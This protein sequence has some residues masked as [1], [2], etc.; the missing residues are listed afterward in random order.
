MK[1]SDLIDLLK[2]LDQAR[3]VMVRGYEWGVN[4]IERVETIWIRRDAYDVGHAGQHER[5][6]DHDMTATD[7]SGRDQAYELVGENRL[8]LIGDA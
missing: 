2:G 1:V 3:D 4:D 8:A 5:H 7:I 6:D